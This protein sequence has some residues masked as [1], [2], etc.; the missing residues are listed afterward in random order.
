MF[1]LLPPFDREIVTKL[2]RLVCNERILAEQI[3]LE[4][5]AGNPVIIQKPDTWQVA[6]PKSTVFVSHS[7]LLVWQRCVHT[8]ALDGEAFSA[9]G[10]TSEVFDVTILRDIFEDAFINT[11][12]V[13]VDTTSAYVFVVGQVYPLWRARM[14]SG[15]VIISD[16]SLEVGPQK[17]YCN[18]EFLVMEKSTG[19]FIEFDHD[20]GYGNRP[21]C[22][23]CVDPSLFVSRM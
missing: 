4:C 12:M 17:E 15:M 3:M 16:S 1:I 13:F 21:F 14:E 2:C 11:D 18:A 10:V 7:D 6:I 23:V 5:D 19:N 9:E 8:N 20:D 22:R